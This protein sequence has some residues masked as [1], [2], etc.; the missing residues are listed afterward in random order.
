MEVATSELR[1]LVAPC[2]PPRDTRD[3]NR[4]QGAANCGLGTRD[5][6]INAW[7]RQLLAELKARGATDRDQRSARLTDKA[8][9]REMAG[10]GAQTLTSDVRGWRHPW[11]P[12]TEL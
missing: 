10:Q 1:R 7:N 11:Q 3:A 8:E 5:D 12:Q 6:S 9:G 2:C 4:R